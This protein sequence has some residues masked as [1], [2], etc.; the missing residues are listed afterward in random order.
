MKNV[1]E[2]RVGRVVVDELGEG[3]PLVLLH[4]AGH[5]RRDFAAIVPTLSTRFRTLAVDWPG[6]GESVVDAPAALGASVLFDVLEDV[7]TGLRLPPAIVLGNSVGGGAAVRLAARRPAAVRGL[8]LV[9][10][11]GFTE[12]G[13]LVRAFCRVQGSVLVRRLTGRA[14]A[15]SYLHR[16]SP[17]AADLLARVGAATPENHVAHAAL[18]RS[19]AEPSASVMEE[20]AHVRCPVFV[21][22]GRHDPILRLA[23]EGA[24]VRAAF[25]RAPFEVVDTGHVPF[26]EDPEGF[27]ALVGP[28]LDGLAATPALVGESASP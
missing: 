25:P 16:R 13:A 18:W 24:R 15:R 9:D 2:T 5:D 17:A 14:F 22:W 20:A 19:F 7:V 4:G 1:V 8:V 12:R 10:T 23:H 26:I 28:F 11:S 27:L 3:T 6:F 21:V